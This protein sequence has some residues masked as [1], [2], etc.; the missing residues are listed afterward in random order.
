MGG[1]PD[2]PQYEPQPL[3]P[4]ASPVDESVLR[5]RARSK[6]RLLMGQ[7][8]KSTILTGGVTAGAKLG[9]PTLLGG[10]TSA[11]AGG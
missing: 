8:R 10:G 11:A 1:G 9:A 7:G 5:A 4:P 6:Q 3:P 2:I